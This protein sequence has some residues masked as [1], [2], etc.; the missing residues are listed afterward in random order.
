V[1]NIEEKIPVRNVLK[2]P[3]EPLGAVNARFRA[4]FCGAQ[5]ECDYG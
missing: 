2:I 3:V 4:F 1:I 5:V